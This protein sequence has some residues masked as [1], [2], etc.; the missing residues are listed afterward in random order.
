MADKFSPQQIAKEMVEAILKPSAN[1][2]EMSNLR[3]ISSKMH[4]D[5]W[6]ARQ[7]ALVAGSGALCGGAGGP[8]GIVLMLADLVWLGKNSGQGCL[9]VGY[10]L[11]KPVSRDDM[12]LIL[13]IWT[14]I[15]TPSDSVPAGTVAISTSDDITPWMQS[16]SESSL[17]VTGKVAAKMG[18]KSMAKV[19]GKLAGKIIAKKLAVKG[20]SKLGAKL[21]VL[22]VSFASSKLAAKLAAKLGSSWVPFM[23]GLVSA[24]INFW[25]MSGLL[26][27]AEGFYTHDFIVVNNSEVAAFAY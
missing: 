17:V 11:G 4:V 15:A 19:S 20:G 10:A 13:A 14:G 2:E 21:A 1:E 5:N 27:A 23:G 8:G 25:L 3:K 12:D 26:D 18:A 9:G 22:A 16:A 7:L 24:G 6:K